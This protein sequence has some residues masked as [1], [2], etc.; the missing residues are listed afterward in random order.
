ML[1]DHAAP[2]AAAEPQPIDTSEMRELVVSHF[3]PSSGRLGKIRGLDTNGELRKATHGFLYDG[4]VERKRF[5]SVREFAEFANNLP[6]GQ[7]IGFGLVDG[8]SANIVTSAAKSLLPD[9]AAIV[10]RTKR[11]FQYRSVPGVL[12]I[13][14]DPRPDQQPFTPVEL[15]GILRS[16]VPELRQ[17]A[18][19]GKSSSSAYLFGPDGQ[20]LVGAA[21]FHLSVPVADASLIPQL[22]AIIQDRLWLNGHGYAKITCA[23]T[24]K[25]CTPID[26]SVLSPE[27]IFFTRAMCEDGVTQRL[28]DIDYFPGAFDEVL[29]REGFLERLPRLTAEEQGAVTL[30]KN[31]ASHE[32]APEAREIRR[33]WAEGQADLRLKLAADR[34]EPIN[35]A[36]VLT[37]IL[38]S[39]GSALPKDL[40]LYPQGH[41]PITA[42]EV[43]SDPERWAAARF[44]DPFEPDYGDDPRIAC[45]VF[46]SGE[47]YIYSHAH[48]GS[49]YFFRTESEWVSGA[50]AFFPLAQSRRRFEAVPASEFAEGHPARWLVKGL[51]PDAALAVIYGAPASGKSFF[52]LDVV[53]SIALGAE[54]NTRK[55]VQT[56]VVYICAEG[57]MGFRK[58][59]RA[60]EQRF[61]VKLGERLRIIGDQPDLLGDRDVT[62]LIAELVRVE[63]RV[64]V[65]DTLAQV[66][67]G[68]DENSAVDMGKVLKRCREIQAATQATVVLIHHAG[69]DATRGPRGWSGLLAAADA[70]I[71]VSRC[72][73]GNEAK[74]SKMK[75][76]EDSLTFPFQLISESLGMDEDGDPITS[77]TVSYN[78][79]ADG[80]I[81]KSPQPVGANQIALY[82]AIHKLSERRKRVTVTEAIEKACE[83]VPYDRGNDKT[84]SKRD[85]RRDRLMRAMETMIVRNVLSLEGDN[86][87]IAAAPHA[88]LS[89]FEAN[90]A[91]TTVA[92][93]ASPPL[94]GEAGE[95]SGSPTALT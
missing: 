28:P 53:C 84:K 16:S 47:P 51:L 87:A 44:A 39:A 65:I 25:L 48:G 77:C 15:V 85:Q 81:R 36:D 49:S 93:A 68:G 92:S 79:V 95:A 56:T 22:G 74:I 19:A 52:A 35:R 14:Y 10:S 7:A 59:I 13:D 20:T 29:E 91:P 12:T 62:G 1:A 33:Q 78:Q 37:E 94:R 64:I 8:V 6:A 82:C 17:V 86:I 57:A 30:L 83:S 24:I 63:P 43:Y 67:P 2:T 66:M 3:T 18:I 9:D 54:W 4:V 32:A 55:V 61:E 80:G 5:S 88:S 40:V 58:R 46:D 72:A 42:W 73:V 69:K 45:A 76:G 26:G 60:Y 89:A 27:R 11:Y 41:A 21:G 50:D 71:E 90:E 34:G 70:V 23:G 31:A 75:D 38:M